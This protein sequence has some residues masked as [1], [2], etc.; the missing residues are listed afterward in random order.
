MLYKHVC[1][2]AGRLDQV[3]ELPKVSQRLLC[4]TVQCWGTGVVMEEL[5][6]VATKLNM[7]LPCD[8]TDVLAFGF[9]FV[10][11]ILSCI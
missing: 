8:M 9:S 2:A 3:Q 10:H 4:C 7:S 6:A 5:E 11:L 1:S